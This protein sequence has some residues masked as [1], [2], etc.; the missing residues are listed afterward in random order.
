MVETSCYDRQGDVIRHGDRYFPMES[1]PCT[2]CT[3][4]KGMPE[5]CISVFCY[6]PENCQKYHAED[7]KCCQ[8]VCDDESLAHFPG[9]GKNNSYPADNG[10]TTLNATNLGLRLVAGAVTSLLILA[11]LLFMINRLRRRRLL[12][13]IRRFHSRGGNMSESQLSQRFSLDGDDAGMGYFMG[14]DHAELGPFDDPS[15][16]YAF[17]KPPETYIPPGE[18]PPPYE[19]SVENVEAPYSVISLSP[20]RRT[21]QVDVTLPPHCSSSPVQEATETPISEDSSCESQ[22]DKRPSDET[23]S[24]SQPVLSSVNVT[25]ENEGKETSSVSL[26]NTAIRSDVRY[27][28]IPIYMPDNVTVLHIRDRQTSFDAALRDEDITNGNILMNPAAVEKEEFRNEQSVPASA[29]TSHQQPEERES[30]PQ[31][32]RHSYNDIIEYWQHRLQRMQGNENKRLSLQPVSAG[33]NNNIYPDP[34]TWNGEVSETSSSSSPTYEQRTFSP[35]SS[36]SSS[37]DVDFDPN[38][39]LKQ[40]VSN[41]HKSSNQ[42]PSQ[43]SGSTAKKFSSVDRTIQHLRRFSLNRKNKK[44]KNRKR[45]KGKSSEQASYLKRTSLEAREFPPD[46]NFSSFTVG[47]PVKINPI[48]Q[49]SECICVGA[50]PEAVNPHVTDSRSLVSRGIDGQEIVASLAQCPRKDP[51]VHP[52]NL[53]TAS[54]TK[55]STYNMGSVSPELNDTTFHKRFEPVS[56]TVIAVRCSTNAIVNQLPLESRV[57]SS[58][59]L[60]SSFDVAHTSHQNVVSPAQGMFQASKLSRSG[61]VCSETGERKFVLHKAASH[62]SKHTIEDDPVSSFDVSPEKVS[63]AAEA[64]T[65]HHLPLQQLDVPLPSSFQCCLA[66]RSREPSTSCHTTVNAS[67]KPESSKMRRDV[68][69]NYSRRQHKELLDVPDVRERMDIATYLENNCA[70]GATPHIGYITQNL[71]HFNTED[72]TSSRRKNVGS[73]GSQSRTNDSSENGTVGGARPRHWNQLRRC[74]KETDDVKDSEGLS[75]M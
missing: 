71:N 41:P 7:D 5:M 49:D 18:A 56:P 70:S 4:T 22:S 35:S 28:D 63:K 62:I 11:L 19:A 59:N 66:P 12:L 40:N 27:E 51:S 36:D 37:M 8:F 43:V 50:S 74:Q 72:K 58:N 64:S 61:S 47:S 6:P 33:D 54:K 25:C 34:T 53:C 21:S 69:S 3:C 1:D 75:D 60:Q 13:M 68:T 2:Q 15:P 39:G 65:R 30:V 10:S 23:S 17:W 55:Y 9:Y 46:S 45:G 73:N 44:K 52:N 48:F 14:R 38:G 16:P 32:S 24:P 20:Y 42:E 57:P 31:G 26:G 67:H 29:V